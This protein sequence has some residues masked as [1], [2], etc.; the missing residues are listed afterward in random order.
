M[1]FY[2][3]F[4][5]L[6][7]LASLASLAL[8]PAQ[9]N[10]QETPQSW[11]DA[12]Q[13][14]VER[15]KSYRHALAEVPIAR[16]VILFVGDGM[17]VST[18]TAARI[19]EGQLRGE[20]GEENAL[21]FESFPNVALSKTY[22]SNSQVPDSAG[23]MTAM[24]TGVKTDAGLI[25]V[26]QNVVRGDC[27]SQTGNH[28][29]TFLELA[30]QR[31]IATGV[32]T[33]ARLTHATPASNYAHSMERDFE[34][35][36]DR[37]SVANPADCPD[38]ARQLIEFIDTHPDS[39]GLEVAMG[40]GRRSFLPRQRGAADPETGNP[41]ERLDDRN[42]TEEWLQKH[43][44]ATYVWNK[45]QFDAIDPAE[46]EHLLGLF[47]PSHMEYSLDIAT[48]RGGE[49][50]LSEMTAKA[51]QIL[52]RNE[53]GYYLNVE[54]GRIDH[55]HHAINPQ[56]ALLDTIELAR[57]VKTAVDMVDLN[58]TLIIVTAD[59]SHVFTM[60]GYPQRGNPIL[61]KVLGLDSSGAPEETERLA[62]DG[63]PY[64]T[65]GYS[66][67][68]GYHFIPDTNTADSIYSTD[69]NTRGRA[70]L[71]NVDTTDKGFHSE[72]LVPLMDETHGGEDVAI[73]AIGPGADLVR[74]VMEQNVIFHIMMEASQ[75][76]QR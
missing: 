62:A 33:T 32:V 25:G 11:F 44:N 75:L 31:G 2:P 15:S 16:N 49:P 6:F 65:L 47:D 53:K 29:E 58:E 30:E 5:T 18:V 45:Q 59:H 67:G 52:A 63:L 3:R 70:D 1:K 24:T 48:D 61:G 20:T 68:P 27:D 42:L 17:G 22:N 57:A 34:D 19:L 56:R 74:G 71:S 7:F 14:A 76:S 23:T 73:Y 39:D 66:N 72:T 37:V 36:G 4:T 28:L 41:S 40:G 60:A 50:S 64:T 55:A 35:D 13:A 43:E 21:F 46:T 38:I 51:I 12:G 69:I 54:A 10:S 8:F 9:V 26:N